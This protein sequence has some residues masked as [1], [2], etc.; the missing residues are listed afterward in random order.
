MA[1]ICLHNSDRFGDLVHVVVSMFEGRVRPNMNEFEVRVI[2]TRSLQNSVM[3]IHLV[4]V[5]MSV[6]AMDTILNLIIYYVFI[7]LL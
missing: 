2:P 7:I 4:D 5:P 3:G 6:F 1:P